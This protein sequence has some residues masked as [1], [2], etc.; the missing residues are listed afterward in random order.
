MNP[1]TLIVGYTSKLSKE[2]DR[3]IKSSSETRAHFEPPN[4]GATE[5]SS[6][7]NTGFSIFS[8]EHNQER[9]TV[10]YLIGECEEKFRD[11]LQ[12]EVNLLK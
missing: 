11:A 10:A 9:Q 2:S 4:D 5:Q 12:T 6:I 1:K 8:E 7:F 3:L